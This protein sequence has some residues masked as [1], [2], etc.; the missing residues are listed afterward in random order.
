[1]NRRFGRTLL[2]VI[3][4]LAPVTALVVTAAPASAAATTTAAF[5]SLDEPPGST[6]LIDSS[7]HGRN[8]TIG[9]DVELG[10]LFDGAT[11]HRFPTIS[12]TAPPARP[13]H[14]N[15][16]PHSPP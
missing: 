6:T 9:S 16:V 2:S 15:R 11:A 1:M 14:I 13:E 12:P 3:A 10:T 8:G 7:G 4:L 5:W